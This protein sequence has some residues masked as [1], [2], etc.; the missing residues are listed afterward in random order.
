MSANGM[1]RPCSGPASKRS[2]RGTRDEEHAMSAKF[3]C[4][5]AVIG[6]DMARTRFT[7]CATIS[8]GAAVL[9]PQIMIPF[10]PVM[11]TGNQSC[12]LISYADPNAES[13]GGRGGSPGLL[14]QQV[15]TNSG[16]S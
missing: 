4:E 9:R 16:E 6:I 15:I 10:L 13:P 8:V 3:N 5:V 14:V 1:V 11:V 2:W 7:S 12:P